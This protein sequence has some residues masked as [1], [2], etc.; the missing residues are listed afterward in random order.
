MPLSNEKIKNKMYW[1]F[2][3]KRMPSLIPII[4]EF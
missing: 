3:N 2:I 1:K 4:K